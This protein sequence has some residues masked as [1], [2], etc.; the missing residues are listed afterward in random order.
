MARPPA[1]PQRG[2]EGGHC[3][4]GFPPRPVSVYAASC[5]ARQKRFEIA[6]ATPLMTA[7]C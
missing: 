1:M 5:T 3:E 4:L 7:E 2:N 6:Y